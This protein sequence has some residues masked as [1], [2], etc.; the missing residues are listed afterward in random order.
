MAGGSPEWRVLRRDLGRGLLVVAPAS[1]PELE[2]FVLTAIAM[3]LMGGAGAQ[4]AYRGLV[5]SSALA[6]VADICRRACF[7]FGDENHFFLGVGFLLFTFVTIM[8]ARN[9][10]DALRQA[11]DLRPGARILAS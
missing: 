8:F 2:V 11:G 1:D 6:A 10:E 3:V 9:Q 7:R 5:L 4:A